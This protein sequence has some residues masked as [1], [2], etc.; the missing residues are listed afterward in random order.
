MATMNVS[1]P[2]AMKDWVE[3]RVGTGQYANASDYVRDLIRL[4]QKRADAREKLQQM[5]DDALASGVVEMTSEELL[6]RVMAKAEAAVRER[7]SA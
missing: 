4:D 2:D 7:K 1:L 5:V 6:E 3:S